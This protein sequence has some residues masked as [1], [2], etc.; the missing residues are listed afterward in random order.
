MRVNIHGTVYGPQ[1]SIITQQGRGYK[2]TKK[3]RKGGTKK[4]NHLKKISRSKAKTRKK[5]TAT[6]KHANVAHILD[7]CRT[8]APEPWCY[9]TPEPRE[10][11]SAS[12]LNIVGPGIRNRRNQHSRV[13]SSGRV[14]H[15]GT[16]DLL[17]YES[18]F[19]LPSDPYGPL[20]PWAE[21][22]PHGD[23]TFSI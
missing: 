20:P 13:L 9:S 5:S 19:P 4:R 8:G 2:K 6:T 16:Q 17:D 15:L 1:G 7:A 3:Y 14:D 11:R 12:S 22:A 21:P 18:T 23:R 10:N